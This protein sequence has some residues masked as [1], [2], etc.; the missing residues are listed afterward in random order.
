M[1]QVFATF[2]YT[3]L[4]EVVISEL[5]IQGVHEIYA[6]PLEI[7]HPEP[8]FIDSMYYTDGL[9]FT[10][11]GF[12]FAFLF[13]TIG[14]SKGFVWEWGP[15]IWGLIGGGSGFVLGVFASWCLYRFRHG[16]GKRHI[17][18]GIKGE[19]I[20]IVTCSAEQVGLVKKLLWEH[21]AIGVAVTR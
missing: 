21:S 3:S 20:L 13:A 5:K 16:K 4:L 9:S 19:V 7:Q 12:I 1:M 17:R 2:A 10:D 15:I 8:K 6:V 14:A 18:R 11:T